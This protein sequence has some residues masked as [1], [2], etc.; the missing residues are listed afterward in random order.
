M[1]KNY[2]YSTMT[3]SVAYALYKRL[4][5]ELIQEVEGTRVLINGNSHVAVATNP[6]KTHFMTQKGAVTVVTDEQL[7]LLKNNPVFD[8]H[9]KNG[10]IKID[11]KKDIDNAIR[12]LNKKDKSAPYCPEDYEKNGR[13]YESGSRVKAPSVGKVNE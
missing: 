8:I 2:I 10:F 13:R 12:D 6:L 9:L 7:E 4:H 5:G 1:N 3:G 11:S